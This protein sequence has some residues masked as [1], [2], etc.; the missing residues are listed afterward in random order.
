MGESFSNNLNPSFALV[1][2]DISQT[3]GC[4]WDDM[5]QSRRC[6]FLYPEIEVVDR[7]EIREDGYSDEQCEARNP[8]C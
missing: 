3:Y 8:D 6:Y 5:I 7:E 2:S 1:D 4:I